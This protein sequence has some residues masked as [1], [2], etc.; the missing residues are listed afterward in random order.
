VAAA[1]AAARAGGYT[2]NIPEGTI[3]IS[4]NLA[5]EAG[6][7]TVTDASGATVSTG[8]YLSVAQKRDGRWLMIRDT[9]NSDAPPAPPPPPAPAEEAAPAGEA[10]PTP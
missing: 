2:N 7:F 3:G 9:W 6:N 1:V 4:G 5:W 10:A 8:K